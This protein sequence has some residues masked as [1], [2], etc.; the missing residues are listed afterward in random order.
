M[1]AKW[2]MV[3]ASEIDL[4]DETFRCSVARDPDPLR[5]S[6]ASVGILIPLRLQDVDGRLR[7][8]SGFLRAEALKELGIEAWPVQIIHSG[9][10]DADLFVGVLHENRFQ[11]GFSWA[12][13]VLAVEKARD[14]FGMDEERLLRDLLPAMDLPPAP[15]ILRDY[16]RAAGLSPLL[17]EELIRSGCSLANALRLLRW[18]EEDQPALIPL[19]RKLHLG[20]NRLRECIETLYEIALREGKGPSAI[21]EESEFKEILDDPRQDRPQRTE[22]FRERL[23]RRRYP[24]F[25]AM[26]RSFFQCRSRLRIPP[27]LSVQASPYFE[28]VGVRVSFRARSREEFQRMAKTIWSIAE[29][30]KDLEELFL[31][32][33]ALPDS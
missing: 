16:L 2:E 23:I 28:E 14:I 7:L 32:T 5:G 10:S 17:R 15:R 25:S 18:P 11:R 8:L 19:L 6:I 29:R 13:R 22:A 3:S 31:S 33:S 20:E 1:E 26:R 21:L 4:R 30:E 9:G 27:D 24:L 12:E